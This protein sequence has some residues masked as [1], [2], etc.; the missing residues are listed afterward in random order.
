MQVITIKTL[1]KELIATTCNHTHAIA[2]CLSQ[3][4]KWCSFIIVSSPIKTMKD[5]GIIGV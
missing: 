2:R 4:S 3:K 1:E 5:R